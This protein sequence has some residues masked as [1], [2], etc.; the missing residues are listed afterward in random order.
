MT[1]TCLLAHVWGS[2]IGHWLSKTA[3]QNKGVIMTNEL[4]KWSSRIMQA[5]A[6]LLV[7]AVL[8]TVCKNHL[9]TLRNQQTG[10]PDNY[11]TAA[12]RTQQLECLTRNI[13][14]EAASEPFE[15]KV[16]VAQVTLNRLESGR[17]ANSVCGVVYQ[18]NVFYER[19]VCQ[20]SWY[21]ENKS[22]V[23]PVNSPMWEESETV[24]KKVLLE[25]FRLPGLKHAIYYH[26][27]YVNPGWNKPRIEKIGRH[28]FYGERL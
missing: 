11:V 28:I 5:L 2:F 4:T 6:L 19:V 9:D 10:M 20:F 25:G 3:T 1:K 22:R 21:C 24:A 27:D 15:G 18:K 14:H 8:I 13:Y 7:S 23:R 17:F 16:G 26:A 12:E